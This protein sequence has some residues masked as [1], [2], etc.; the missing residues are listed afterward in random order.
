MSSSVN[1]GAMSAMGRQGSKKNGSKFSP[2]MAAIIFLS[3]VIFVFARHQ[4]VGTGISIDDPLVWLQGLFPILIL[5]V[6]NSYWN[7]F[8]SSATTDNFWRISIS[9]WIVSLILLILLRSL[10]VTID[11]ELFLFDHYGDWSLLSTIIMSLLYAGIGSVSVGIVF[12]FYIIYYGGN[13]LAGFA[14]WILAFLI[15]AVCLN[16]F[17]FWS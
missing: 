2:L 8:F 10:F 12:A 5:G 9:C 15:S 1:T 11:Y 7:K 4:I 13:Y 17:L 6:V 14:S 16:V 3:L